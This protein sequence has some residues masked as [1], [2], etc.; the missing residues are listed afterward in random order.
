M[1]DNESTATVPSI[2]Y[3]TFI[4]VA[5]SLATGVL[6]L[7]GNS[8]TIEGDYGW[9]VLLPVAA[10]LGCAIVTHRAIESL[11][12]GSIIGFLLLDP[13]NILQRMIDEN[14]A[15]LSESTTAWI[16]TITFLVGGLVALI[17]CSGGTFA[18]SHWVSR[19]AKNRYQ[20][21]IIT[22]GMGL[23]IFVD[24]YLNALA[25]SSS[26]KK[27]CDKFKVS[28]QMLAY[29]VDSTS[30]PMCV[31]VPIST[32]SIFLI[33]LFEANG[34]FAE[35]TGFNGYLELIPYIF[36]AWVAVLMVPLVGMGWIPA[37]GNMKKAEADAASGLLPE[38][39]GFQIR[40]AANPR[41]RN[42]L[43]PLLA[44]MVATW[45][46]DYNTLNGIVFALVFT[47]LLFML[48]QLGTL[49]SLVDH[50]LD[51][52]ASMIQP[53]T[54][55]ICSFVLQGI[56]EELGLSPFVLEQVVP[57]MDAA[58]LP[59]ITFLVLS[60][61]TFATGSFWGIYAIALPVIFPL[62]QAVGAD[63]SVTMGALISAGVFGSHACFFGDA[64]VITSKGAGCTPYSHALTQLPYAAIAAAFTTVLFVAFA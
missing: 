44:F 48:Q 27:L 28:R 17:N 8:V 14:I 49:G 42:F 33:G 10:V 9:F 52:F 16:V 1:T 4:K 18:F 21:L 43:L 57:Y 50:V 56:N 26:M 22:W 63:I 61:L 11:L 20:T 5:A 23:V 47:V 29:V 13:S 25:V 37:L 62:A 34:V 38:S 53:M 64:T 6:A 31:L 39:E 45:Y 58:W 12:F 55:V 59:A 35:G 41:I 24:D 19:Y 32:W 60:V 2:H 7:Y 30:A 15:V 3:R 46:F 51:G 36:Y 54:V 40:S